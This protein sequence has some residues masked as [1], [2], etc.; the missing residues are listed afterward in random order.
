MQNFQH[1]DDLSE[2]EKARA[3]SKF[4]LFFADIVEQLSVNVLRNEVCNTVALFVLVWEIDDTI[5]TV[6]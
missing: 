3:F 5:I 1:I 2:E 4:T 6:H